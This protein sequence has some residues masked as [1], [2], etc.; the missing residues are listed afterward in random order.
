MQEL[1]F[2]FE[3]MSLNLYMTVNNASG[4]ERCQCVYLLLVIQ[5]LVCRLFFRECKCIECVSA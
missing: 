1:S 5:E 4:S 2:L 3:R